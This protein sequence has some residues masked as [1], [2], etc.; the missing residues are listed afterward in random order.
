MAHNGG[1][2]LPLREERRGN[3][4]CPVDIHAAERVQMILLHPGRNNRMRGNFVAIFFLM[5]AV[6]TAGCGSNPPALSPQQETAIQYN[7]RGR[8]AFEQGNY[9]E[10]RAAYQQALAIHQSVEN[11]EGIATELMNLSVVHRRL[12]VTTAAHGVLDQI[13]NPSGLSFSPAHRAEA[14]YRKASFYLEDGNRNEAKSWADK[15]LGFCQGCGTEGKLYNLLARMSLPAN[16]QETLSLARRAL[17]LNRN[18]GDKIEEANSLR[19]IADAAFAS[20]DFKTAQQFYGDALSLDKDA[21][22]AAK[23]ALDLMGL[24]RSLARQGKRTEAVDYFQRAYSVSEGAGDTKVMDD[25]MVE[26]RKLTR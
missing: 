25:A 16:P 8:T 21:G 5:L 9:S 7:Q 26:I 10:A 20:G 2:P 23:I 6:L 11:T 15:A 4:E 13:I 18:A 17:T 3:R 22:S 24:G 12:G 1:S 14:A 19:L